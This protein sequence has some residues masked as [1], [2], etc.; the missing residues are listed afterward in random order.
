MAAGTVLKAATFVA[1]MLAGLIVQ[2]GS[3]QVKK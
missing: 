2:A 1:V 3:E